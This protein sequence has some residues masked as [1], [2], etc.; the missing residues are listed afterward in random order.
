MD[1]FRPCRRHTTLFSFVGRAFVYGAFGT[2]THGRHRNRRAR[3]YLASRVYWFRVRPRYY[4][5]YLRYE[6]VIY[7]RGGGSTA[8]CSCL[9]CVEDERTKKFLRGSNAHLALVIL[10]LPWYSTM[11][12]NTNNKRPQN[13]SFVG[14]AI[15]R[16][17]R[18]GVLL[19]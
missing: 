12:I 1:T 5:I 17:V 8:S 4:C 19:I 14:R 3:R 2:R 16:L 7:G 9:V 18:K 6:T 15:L 13:R 11:V 10:V